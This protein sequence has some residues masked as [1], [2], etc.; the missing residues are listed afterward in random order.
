[1]SRFLSLSVT[2]IALNFAAAQQKPASSNAGPVIQHHQ[3]LHSTIDAKGNTNYAHV[4]VVASPS[5]Q[6][7]VIC[8]GSHSGNPNVSGACIPVT[9]SNP[10]GVLL[11][12]RDHVNVSTSG[13]IT[14]QCQ[15]QGESYC[16]ADIYW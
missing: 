8:S 6:A 2:L 13:R 3:H 14:L 10:G 15:G 12:F 1:M 4:D 16:D 9:P 11:K 7:L 5:S